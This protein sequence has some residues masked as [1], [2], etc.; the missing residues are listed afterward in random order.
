M[1]KLTA[2]KSSAKEDADNCG[3][4]RIVDYT[5]RF[6][7][8]SKASNDV[9]AT[10]IGQTGFLNEPQIA[11]DLSGAGYDSEIDPQ[12]EAAAAMPPQISKGDG[13]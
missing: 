11:A 1:T 6:I 5:N 12:A 2:L 4:Y 13:R 8:P 3:D 7:N 9:I 10:V